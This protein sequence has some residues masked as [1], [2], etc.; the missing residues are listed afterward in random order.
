LRPASLGASIR[1]LSAP[2]D[3]CSRD[4]RQPEADRR[5][6]LPARRERGDSGD[7]A[8]QQ[9]RKGMGDAQVPEEDPGPEAHEG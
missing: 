6:G 3:A 1:S 4:H 2:T 7:Q 9:R 5:S 8:V